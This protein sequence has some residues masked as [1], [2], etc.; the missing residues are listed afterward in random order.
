MGAEKTVVR[1]DFV[2]EVAYTG[3]TCMLDTWRGSQPSRHRLA[4]ITVKVGSVEVNQE[5][6][7]AESLDC[8]ALL[9]ADIGEEVTIALMHII[10]SESARKKTVP[11]KRRDC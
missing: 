11:V 8:P 7:V 4:W 2:P 9:G 6:A 10:I 5:V 1:Q 3:R